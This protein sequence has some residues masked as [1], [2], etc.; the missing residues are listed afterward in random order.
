LVQ[1]MNEMQMQGVQRDEQLEARI[2]S[3][4][5]AF[6]AQAAATDAFDIAKEPPAV[7]ERYGK[8]ELAAK[9]LCA[10]RLVERGVRFVQIDAG[11]WDHHSN[12]RA[13]IQ[14]TS[15]AIDKPAGAL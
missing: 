2:R 7:Q 4:E 11:G 14:R 5:L 12:L 13:S 10:R 9:L 3:F 6:H 15:E 1:K 8:S